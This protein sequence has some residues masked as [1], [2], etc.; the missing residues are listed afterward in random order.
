MRIIIGPPAKGEDFWDRAEELD[1]IWSAIE[2]N[3]ILLTAPRRFGKTSIMQRMENQPKTGWDVLYFDVE[4]FSNPQEFIAE[5]G[6][7]FLQRK[8]LANSIKLVK[9][10]FGK[11]AHRIELGYAEFKLSFKQVLEE[12]WQKKG[13]QLFNYFQHVS[14]KTIIIIDELPMMMDAMQKKSGNGDTRDFLGWL[15]SMRQMPALQEK[16]RWVTGGS[17]GI[18]KVLLRIGCGVKAINDLERISIRELSPISARG[19]AKALLSSELSSVEI[20]DTAVEEILGACP[21]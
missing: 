1:K 16:I 2:T 9:E 20:H 10:F 7:I 8:K 12:D 3:S 14:K 17:I 21:T 6:T 19:F 18:D 11:S 15:R 4:K 5:I 13:E